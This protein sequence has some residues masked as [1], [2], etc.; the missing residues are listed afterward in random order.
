MTGTLKAL[1]RGL[2]QVVLISRRRD[3]RRHDDGR[4]LSTG[5][6]V[7]TLLG[8]VNV[9]KRSTFMS[10]FMSVHGGSARTGARTV[11]LSKRMVSR[12]RR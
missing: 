12:A 9:L 7:G 6:Q 1:L 8:Q 5:N 2:T 10:Y 4:G 3:G 11:G